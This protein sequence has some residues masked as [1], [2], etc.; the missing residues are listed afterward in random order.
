MAGELRERSG[1]LPQGGKVL[2]VFAEGGLQG[3]ERREEMELG[4]PRAAEL[5]DEP[6]V[7][8]RLE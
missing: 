7:P 6:R 5:P 1:H 4:H 2:E 3:W 8:P